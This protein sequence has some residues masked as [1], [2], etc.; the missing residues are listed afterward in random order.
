MPAYDRYI[1]ERF[2]RCLDLYLCPRTRRKRAFVKDPETLVPKLP[3][4]QEL[5]P[6]PTSLL[7]QFKGHAAQVRLV[8]LGVNHALRF[9]L[10]T[11]MQCDKVISDISVCTDSSVS[12]T[13]PIFAEA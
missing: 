11:R 9:I 7:I 2:E 5:Q 6:F 12:N 1:K 4:P 10:G 13:S 8:L 3:K